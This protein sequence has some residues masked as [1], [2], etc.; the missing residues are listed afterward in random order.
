MKPKTPK[1]SSGLRSNGL[2]DVSSNGLRRQ[3]WGIKRK[4]HENYNQ[5]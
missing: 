1:K 5:Y 4:H 2:F 3:S